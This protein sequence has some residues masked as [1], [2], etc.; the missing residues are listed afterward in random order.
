MPLHNPSRAEAT[1][2]AYSPVAG[3]HGVD[4]RLRLALALLLAV[5]LVLAAAKAHGRQ[6]RIRR[7]AEG[8]MEA[9]FRR[10]SDPWVEALWQ[11]DRMAFWSAFSLLGVG[12]LL[13][14]AI[15]RVAGRSLVPAPDG[16]SILLVVELA[17]AAAFVAATVRA[18]AELARE[19]KRRPEAKAW[20]GT[21]GWLALVVVLA[22][23]QLWVVW[24]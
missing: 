10:A 20:W 4:D 18:A 16:W 15:A 9:D 22:F 12:G 7:E 24:S 17:F 6:V 14:W 2:S 23:A 3:S 1:R 19:G 13:A 5:P 11:R 8:F 21:L